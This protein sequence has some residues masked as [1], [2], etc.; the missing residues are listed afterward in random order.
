MEISMKITVRGWSRDMGHTTIVAHDVSE[1]RFDK[2]GAHYN[3]SPVIFSNFPEI[4]ILWHKNLKLT[5]DYL[6]S[7]ALDRHE[8]LRLFKLTF[9]SDL[10]PRLVEE[11]GF[12]VS[13][14]LAKLI[15]RTVKLPDL[16]LGDLVAMQAAA[17]EKISTGT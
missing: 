10:G 17:S 11:H 2:S 8:V 4:Q 9:G 13:P 5:G 1:M 7:L 16:T 14:A 12:T 6:V 15:L 3:G